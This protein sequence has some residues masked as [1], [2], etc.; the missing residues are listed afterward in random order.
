MNIIIDGRAIGKGFRPFIIAE[1]S[2]N[3]NQSL[4]RALAIVEAAAKTGVD[5]I[6]LQTYTADTMTLNVDSSD[7]M[8]SE[9]KSLWKGNSLYNLYKQAY[10]PWEWHSEIF[11]K[12]KELGLIVFSSP[13]D[14]SA[15]DFLETLEVPA[16]KIASFENTHLPLI[17]K[18]A[19]TGKPI[20][21]STG[22]ASAAELDE[23]VQ[24]LRESGC[25]QLVLLKCTSTYPAEP[26]NSN[27]ATIPHMKQLFNCEVG[28]S[29]HT[30]GIG[31]SIAS[32]VLGATVIEKHFT[33]SRAEGGVDSAF[34]MEPHEMKSLVEETVKAWQ[35]IGRISYGAT[36]SERDSRKLR[37][38][39]YAS[40][41]IKSGE[42]ISMGN[43]KI[44]RP[45]YGLPPKFL[46]MVMDRTA[47]VDIP[48]GTPITWD[49]I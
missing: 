28:L 17:K 18:V 8:I 22:M 5:A 9:E 48:K 20:I 4:D 41:N 6:K 31:V 30:L 12:C 25:E 10:T 23:A 27:L 35:S 40:E 2:G 33:L 37:R 36:E 11:K 32:V 45:G 1:M 39:I 47:A 16:Y 26:T 29:D 38:S 42:K 34:S 3:H 24:T 7:F 14:E 46:D 19:A 21:M 15:V 13:F 43:I 44:I 49:L